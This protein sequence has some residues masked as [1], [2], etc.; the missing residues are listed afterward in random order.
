L[1]EQPL[2]SIRVPKA[3]E[4]YSGNCR[5]GEKA[6]GREDGLVKQACVGFF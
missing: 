4:N 5:N 3:K 6:C 1:A 2:H